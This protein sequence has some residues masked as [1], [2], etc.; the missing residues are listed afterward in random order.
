[1]V[2]PRVAIEARVVADP[3]LRFSPSGVAVGSFRMV[4]SDRKKDESGEW[5]DGDT[6]WMAVTCFK[7]LAENVAES[8][9]KGDIVV[10]QG[11][12][13]TE[14]WE[15][16]TTGEKKSKVAMI[17]D[18]VSVSLQFRTVPHGGGRTERT[19]S[20]SSSTTETTPGLPQNDE[21]P[22]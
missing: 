1:M 15:D 5:V 3:E 14:E 11:K 9:A 7:N 4:S 12:L 8:V 18:T 10:V 16:K 22:F 17:A 6:L 2:L 19:S 20:S 13:R 21:P